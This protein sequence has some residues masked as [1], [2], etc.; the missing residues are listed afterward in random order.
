MT[1]LKL[2][3]YT[4][5]LHIPRYFTGGIIESYTIFEPMHKPVE[6]YPDCFGFTTMDPLFSYGYN[7]TLWLSAVLIFRIAPRSLHCK[8]IFRS[9]LLWYLFSFLCQSGR[10]IY[11]SSRTRNKN[12]LFVQYSGRSNLVCFSRYHKWIFIPRL[13]Q[14]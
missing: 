10:S 2:F 3:F 13:F 11:E 14:A 1:Y 8:M 9:L 5:I 4:I 6:D 12:L 7:F